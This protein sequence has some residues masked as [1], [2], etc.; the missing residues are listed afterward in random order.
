MI[1]KPTIA[2]LALPR[3]NGAS[4][5]GNPAEKEIGEN[6]CGRAPIRVA[7][8]MAKFEKGETDLKGTLAKLTSNGMKITPP[9]RPDIEET[10]APINPVIKI[11]LSL[12]FVSKGFPLLRSKTNSFTT[13][14][15]S[16][17]AT[18]FFEVLVSISDVSLAP[19]NAPMD[20]LIRKLIITLREGRDLVL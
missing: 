12:S 14:N 8:T 13:I 10:N 17:E 9:P 2:I 18:I 3:K 16:T 6:I 7:M 19:N 1:K 4:A 5:S 11:L 20:A 15:K